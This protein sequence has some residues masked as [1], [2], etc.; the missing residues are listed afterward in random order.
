MRGRGRRLAALLCGAALA[1][2]LGGC[3]DTLTGFDAA[4]YVRGLLDETYQGTWDAVFLSLVDLTEAEA[5]KAH[6]E[7]IDQE[8][9]RFCYQFDLRDDLLDR[10]TRAE[11]EELLEEVTAKAS[12]SVGAAVELDDTRYAVE[13]KVRPMDLFLQ[14]Q[15]DTLDDFAQAFQEDY[16]D[17]DPA[18]MS[19]TAR[20]RF[21]TRYEN[22]W[23][24]GVVELCRAKLG[25]MTYREV[26]TIL[27]LVAPDSAGL[28]GMSDNDFTNLATLILPY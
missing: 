5:Q 7:A 14:V 23:A 19:E 2:A 6:D 26:E 16:A 8:Y 17:V 27:V 3:A 10:D 25:T 11:V 1:L 22:A 4:A 24:R 13:V 15:E 21:W 28:Y 12:Y 20:E 9:Q 18:Q